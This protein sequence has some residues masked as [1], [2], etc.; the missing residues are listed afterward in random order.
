MRGYVKIYR[1]LC[2]HSIWASEKFTRGMAWIDLIL[3][4]THKKSYVRKRGVRIDLH[5]GDVGLSIRELSRIYQWSEGKVRRF[6]KELEDDSM[7]KVKRTNVSITISICNY[8]LYQ[9]NSASTLDQVNY[10]T[11]HKRYPIKNDKNVKNDKK[12]KELFCP[13]CKD[14]KTVSSGNNDY[15]KCDPCDEILVNKYELPY[16]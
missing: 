16:L 2:N 6:I 14:C 10:Q 1:E 7:I 11:T 8:D 12:T 15:I 13:K 4:A 5:R 9:S 3:R